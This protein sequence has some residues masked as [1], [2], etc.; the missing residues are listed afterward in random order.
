MSDTEFQSNFDSFL[1]QGY[2]LYHVDGYDVGGTT[3]FAA[4]WA[5]TG[6]PEWLA[7]HNIANQDYQTAFNDKLYEGYQLQSISGYVRNGQAHFATIWQSVAFANSERNFINAQV[8][9]FMSAYNVPSVSI[10]IAK[11]EK[12]IYAK[13][14][15]FADISVGEKATTDHRFRI[16][17][18]TKPITSTAAFKLIEEGKLSLDDT[19]FGAQG[20]LGQTY[21]TL[22][23]D[24]SIEMIT[25]E[26][27][28]QHTSGGWSSNSNDPS[29]ENMWLDKDALISW[30][31]DNYPVTTPGTSY[32]YSNFGYF[33]MGRVIEEITGSTYGEYVHNAILSPVGAP[34]MALAH[35]TLAERLP[36]EVVYYD[37]TT[38]PYGFNIE[39]MDSQGGWVAT[40]VE[41]LKFL[42]RVDGRNGKSDIL[43]AASVDAMVNSPSVAPFYSHGWIVTYDNRWHD[44]SVQ[45]T[46]TI[47]G[48]LGDG[49]AWAI[50]TNTRD[51]AND[52]NYFLAMD[53]LPFTI[54]N[55]VSDWPKGDFFVSP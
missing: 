6:G 23:Y 55:N 28:L 31:L 8:E 48:N 52:N 7:Q 17:S 22:P 53:Q 9:A 33:L 16:A 19:I 21:G 5:N 32:A 18:L 29:F 1:A 38:D 25:V 42:V 13:A 51:A 44:G 4:I 3:R 37:N 39:N 30:T 36:K 26:D 34:N 10:A 46:R 40:P 20:I 35:N 12:L 24:P 49:Y 11:D 45:G 41:L 50:L 43:Q 15:G 14:F 27:L 54:T 47:M 2:R